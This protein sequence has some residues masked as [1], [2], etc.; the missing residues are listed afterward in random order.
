MRKNPGL[1]VA[2]VATLMLGIGATTAIYTVVYAIIIAPL[3]YPNPDQLVIVWSKVGGHDNGTAAGDFLDWKQQSKSFQQLAAIGIYG[4]MAFAVSQRTP[5]IG[6]RLALGAG[7]GR[8][9]WFV[10]REATVLAL[11]GLAIGVAGAVL[12]GRAMRSTLYGVGAMDF[13]VIVSVAVVLLFTA[14]L[15]SYLPAHRAAAIDPMKALRT[16]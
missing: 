14:L 16:E 5:E 11:F 10:L 6:L 13:S 1:T 7:K 4:P 8:V 3:P 12:V 9:V 15:A 2:V